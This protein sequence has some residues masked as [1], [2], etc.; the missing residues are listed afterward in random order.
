MS[1]KRG[2]V[3]GTYLDLC[4]LFAAKHEHLAV[5]FKS[6]RPYLDIANPTGKIAH[7]EC[8]PQDFL[9]TKTLVADVVWAGVG[10]ETFTSLC[11]L[12][13]FALASPEGCLPG[14]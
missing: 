13:F 1:L 5:F 2:V 3:T 7:L 6:V 9:P 8:M 4:G 11:P 14:N 10:E 12:C